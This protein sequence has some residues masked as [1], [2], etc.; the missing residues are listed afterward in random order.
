MPKHQSTVGKKARAAANTGT[1]YTTA[2]REQAAGLAAPTRTPW[3]G[4]W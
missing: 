2:L 3:C 1:K 4:C